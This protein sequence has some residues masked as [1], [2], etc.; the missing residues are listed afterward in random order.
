MKFTVITVAYNSASSIEET[1]Q[2]ILWQDHKDYEYIVIDG[3]SEDAT[4]SI[5]QRYEPLFEGRMRWKSEKDKGIYDAMNKALRMATG[6]VIGFLNSDDTYNRKDILSTIAKQLKD[7][8][9]DAVYADLHYVNPKTKVPVRYYSSR[10]FRPWAL[11]FGL[12]PGHPTFY[13]R[14]AIY[15]KYGYFNDTYTVAADFDCILRLIRNHKIRT[16]YVRD[17]W[18]SMKKGGASTSGFQS[19]RKGMLEHRRA[20]K[21]NGVYSNT[22]LLS[23][24]YA[25]KVAELVY[26]FWLYK[27]RRRS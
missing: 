24:R 10:W 3:A 13:C 6:E 20:L 22:L 2:S 9:I 8:N 1:F 11:R 25:Y 7:E 14:K 23:L 15:D 18:V 4:L 26:S 19:Y 27:V 17:N 16:K 21:E 5:I 12:I